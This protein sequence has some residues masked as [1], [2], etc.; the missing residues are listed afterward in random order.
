[1]SDNVQRVLEITRNAWGVIFRVPAASLSFEAPGGNH[2]VHVV[3]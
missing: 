1:M 2:V 3:G